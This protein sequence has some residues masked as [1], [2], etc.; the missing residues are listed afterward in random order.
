ME[1]IL[2]RKKLASGALSSLAYQLQPHLGV[3]LDKEECLLVAILLREQL[4]KHPELAFHRAVAADL[5]TRLEYA[6][7][8]QPL[9]SGNILEAA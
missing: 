6:V 3:T 2:T 1:K 5:V 8:T 4:A 9:P 7:P